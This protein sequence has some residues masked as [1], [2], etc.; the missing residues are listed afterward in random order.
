MRNSGTER[1]TERKR[2]RQTD[3]QTDRQRPTTLE[4]PQRDQETKTVAAPPSKDR[5]FWVQE[6]TRGRAAKKYG[7]R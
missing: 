1:H 4:W 3:R 6:E 7:D 5:Q 2:G